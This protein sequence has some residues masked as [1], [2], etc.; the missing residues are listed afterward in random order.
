MLHTL[1]AMTKD[2]KAWSESLPQL[3][4]MS[5]VTDDA[6]DMSVSWLPWTDTE[7]FDKLLVKAHNL[8]AA[9]KIDK[10]Q[11]TRAIEKVVLSGRFFRS[12]EKFEQSMEEKWMEAFV[13][14]LND[15]VALK[16]VTML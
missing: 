12:H 16:F 4:R 10:A 8:L 14:V 11:Y 13:E 2:W 1:H 6:N 9:G 3:R 15:E 7:W 5:E